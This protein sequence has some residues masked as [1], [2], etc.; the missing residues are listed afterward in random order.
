MSDWR[1]RHKDADGR[2]AESTR[3]CKEAALVQALYLEAGIG[4]AELSRVTG[5]PAARKISPGPLPEL[6]H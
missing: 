6:A 2:D 5:R 1:I 4:F 3:L